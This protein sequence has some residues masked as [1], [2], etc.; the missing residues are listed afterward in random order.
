MKIFANTKRV[1][2]FGVALLGCLT[3]RFLP[4]RPPNV[5][6]LLAVQMPFAKRYG[7]LTAFLFGSLSII[8]FDSLTSGI[9][10][11]TLITALLYGLLGIFSALF[12]KSFEANAKNYAL[13][14]FIG[15]ISY[16]ALSGLTIG[17]LLFHQTLTSAFIGQ[18]PFTILH[19]AGAIPFAYFLSPLIDQA[20]LRKRNKKENNRELIIK[21]TPKYIS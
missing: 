14:A 10:V 17:P 2:A 19:L 13:F 8:I 9:G 3:F 12:F 20:I 15:V 16:D 1:W 18:I 21:L 7:M 5:E 4:F 6:P 11:W